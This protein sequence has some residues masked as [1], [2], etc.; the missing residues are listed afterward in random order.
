M[1]IEP[2]NFVVLNK[3]VVRPPAL[4][5][6]FHTRPGMRETSEL[7]SSEGVEEIEDHRG[8]QETEHPRNEVTDIDRA[9]QEER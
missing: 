6:Y 3:R 9:V 8:P 5:F 7:P 2:P 4:R 1:E